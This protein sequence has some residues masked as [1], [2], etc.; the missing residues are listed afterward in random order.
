MARLG[1]RHKAGVCHAGQ[2]RKDAAKE[3]IT[4]D[5]EE[6]SSLVK[7]WS[8]SEEAIAA[9]CLHGSVEGCSPASH[10]DLVEEFKNDQPTS[11][12]SA[13]TISPL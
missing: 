4:I 12:Q 3:P 6:V 8:G 10:E 5:L 1:D 9:A 13:L 7:V 2:C 11:L